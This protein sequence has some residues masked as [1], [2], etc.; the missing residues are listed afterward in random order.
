[1]KTLLQLAGSKEASTQ[2]EKVVKIKNRPF[3]DLVG[4]TIAILSALCSRQ[5]AHSQSTNIPPKVCLLWPRGDCYYTGTFLRF[6]CMKIKAAAE[7]PDGSISQVKFFLDDTEI[8]VATNSPFEI[9]WS[10]YPNG[11]HIISV[12]A[13]DNSG[14]SSESNSASVAFT[15]FGPY[16]PIFELKSPLNGTVLSTPATFLFSVELLSSP[17]CNTGDV[18]FFIGTNSAGVVTQSGYFTASTPEY[19]ATV[20]NV[21][22]GDYLLSV[23]RNGNPST[24]CYAPSTCDPLI[25]HVVKLAVASPRLTPDNHFQFDVVTSYPTNQNI[26]EVSSN[27]LDWVAISTNVPGTNQFTFSESLPAT[28]AHRFHRVRVPLP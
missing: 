23:R 27:L 22:E 21:P 4:L 7:D 9:V 10:A 24:L 5:I 18:E 25:I 2:N 20:T 11:R 13:F 12:V 17:I 16:P 26:I 15:D 14:A 8:G 28:S 6:S 19:S 3:L 1:V